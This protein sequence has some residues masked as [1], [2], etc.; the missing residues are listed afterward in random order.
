MF[1][2]L[3]GFIPMFLNEIYEVTI[4]LFFKALFEEIYDK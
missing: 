2:S 1:K 4:V 3:W